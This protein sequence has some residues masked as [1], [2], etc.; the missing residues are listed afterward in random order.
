[1]DYEDNPFNPFCFWFDSFCFQRE[2]MEA[3]LA[4]LLKPDQVLMKV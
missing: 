2:E 4:R 1:M 3:Q